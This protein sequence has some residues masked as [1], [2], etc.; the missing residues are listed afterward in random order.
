MVGLNLRG[1]KL[2]KLIASLSDRVVPASSIPVMLQTVSRLPKTKFSHYMDRL[3]FVR[4]AGGLDL[5]DLLRIHI[6]IKRI[7]GSC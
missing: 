4:L 5:L 1:W 2:L 7:Q 3:V 6:Y